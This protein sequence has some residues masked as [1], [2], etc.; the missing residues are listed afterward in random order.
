MSYFEQTYGEILDIDKLFLII[1]NYITDT[2]NVNFYDFGSGYGKI[3]NN[4]SNKFKNCYGIEINKE[5]HEYAL[6]NNNKSN[7]FYIHSNFFDIKLLNNYVLF[8]NN[9]CFGEGTQKRLSMKIINESKKGD[10]I[11][12]TKKLKLLNKLYLIDYTLL[13]SWGESEI[14]LYKIF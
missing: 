13:F 5:R 10:L 7:V 9:L 1:K 6:S 4:Y 11:I 3:V 14:Y 8:I 12:V 2:Y